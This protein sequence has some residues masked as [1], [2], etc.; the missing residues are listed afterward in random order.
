M[1]GR[2]DALWEARNGLDIGEQEAETGPDG[3]RTLHIQILPPEALNTLV[4][5]GFKGI[6][7]DRNGFLDRGAAIT[8]QLRTLLAEQPL[9]SKNHRLEFF[10]LTSFATALNAKYTAE[11]WEAARRA[12]LALPPP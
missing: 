3:V 12:A 9:R 2:P 6:Y 1:T 4:V 5:A 8:S 10:N 11:Q 7:I